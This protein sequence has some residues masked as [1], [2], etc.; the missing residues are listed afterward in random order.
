MGEPA[1]MQSL[2]EMYGYLPEA[3]NRQGRISMA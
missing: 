2:L 3:S 1:Q